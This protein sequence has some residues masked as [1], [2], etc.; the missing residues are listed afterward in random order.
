VQAAESLF[1]ILSEAGPTGSY[2][3]GAQKQWKAPTVLRK[4]EQII[5]EV[6]RLEDFL[7]VRISGKGLRKTPT[8]GLPGATT[9]LSPA[10]ARNPFAPLVKSAPFLDEQLARAYA[11]L[12]PESETTFTETLASVAASLSRAIKGSGKGLGESL[13]AK[14]ELRAK[15]VALADANAQVVELVAEQAE[16]RLTLLDEAFG[17]MELGRTLGE[18]PGKVAGLEAKLAEAGAKR[19]A[20]PVNLQNRLQQTM[21]QVRGLA[22]HTARAE[23]AAAPRLF[24]EGAESVPGAQQALPFDGPL[25]GGGM[26]GANAPKQLLDDATPESVVRDMI[27]GN[28][29]ANIVGGDCLLCWH[30]RRV[31]AVASQEAGSRGA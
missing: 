30:E 20:L 27:R 25:Q 17:G 3:K 13:L 2:V 15:W 8:G 29:Q 5:D 24:A 11:A 6:K 10:R 9:K 19:A 4:Y 22:P 21:N 1:H 14:P 7:G 31:V 18:S 28:E 23:H 12:P 26:L 16:K